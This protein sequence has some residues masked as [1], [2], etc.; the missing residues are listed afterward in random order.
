MLRI[1]VLFA[2]V[3]ACVPHTRAGDYACT[4]STDCADGRTCVDRY[5][6][7]VDAPSIDAP[8]DALVCPDVCSSCDLSKATCTI[9]CVAGNTNQCDQVECPAGFACTINCGQNRCNTIDCTNPGSS[10]TLNCTGSG[11]CDTIDCG[12]GRCEINCV[13]SSSCNAIDCK[14]SC[15]CD[16]ECTHGDCRPACPAPPNGVCKSPGAGLCTSAPAN[17]DT[18]L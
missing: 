18:C 6:I 11:S 9:D 12:P 2:L 4:D 16:V 15:A 14:A 5:C 13:G 10:C 7:V 17:C 3:G 8:P 1:L